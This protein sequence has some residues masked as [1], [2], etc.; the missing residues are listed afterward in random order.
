MSWILIPKAG[1]GPWG[2]QEVLNISILVT[3]EV[4]D[5]THVEQPVGAWL[6]PSLLRLGLQGVLLLCSP[7]RPEDTSPLHVAHSTGPASQDPWE[8]QST[9]RKSNEFHP[10]PCPVIFPEV[11]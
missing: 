8:T 7:Y 9:Q 5:V 4:G 11:I 6:F 10:D 1:K 2:T 3:F